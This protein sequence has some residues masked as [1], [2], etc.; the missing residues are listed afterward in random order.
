MSEVKQ[1]VRRNEVHTIMRDKAWYGFDPHTGAFNWPA[2]INNLAHELRLNSEQVYSAIA[3]AFTPQCLSQ[4][5]LTNDDGTDGENIPLLEMLRRSGVQTH[6]W[7][8]G[9][10][11]WQRAKFINSGAA[12]YIKEDNYHCSPSNKLQDLEVIVKKLGVPGR[13]RRF[14][15][16]DDKESN[17]QS[18][19]QIAQRLKENER[20][21]V[22]YH[23]KLNEGEANATAF[24]RWL[25]VQIQEAESVD[26]EIVLILDFDGVVADTDGVLFGPAVDNL[27]KLPLS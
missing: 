5:L 7:T 25:Q 27:E 14:I 4:V 1:S 15:V 17:V 21:I 20:E 12:Q 2:T 3:D 26:E 18:V 9:D 22:D 8:V 23:M 13:K 19:K 16:V 24:Y 6:I 11:D 10:P